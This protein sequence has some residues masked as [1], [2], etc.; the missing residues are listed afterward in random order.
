MIYHIH[1]HKLAFHSIHKHL[2][3][4]FLLHSWR[5]LKGRVI[6]FLKNVVLYLRNYKL[7]LCTNGDWETACFLNNANVVLKDRK[8]S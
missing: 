5:C 2:C 1:E 3:S 8:T 4:S 6:T 7:K